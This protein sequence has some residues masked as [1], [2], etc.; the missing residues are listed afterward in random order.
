M[1]AVAIHTQ[2]SA[3]R[4]DDLKPAAFML[5]VLLPQN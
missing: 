3:S 4:G 1:S 2:T 5:K